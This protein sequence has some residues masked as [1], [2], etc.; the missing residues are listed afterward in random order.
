MARKRF[1][2]GRLFLRGKRT[3]K[4]VGR[5]REDVIASDGSTRRIEKSTVLGTKVEFPTRRLAERRLEQLLAR[6]NALGYRPARVAT[7]GAFAEQWKMKVLAQQ[8]PSSRLAG[9]S[10]LKLYILPEFG[11]MRLDQIGVENQQVFVTRLSKELSRKTVVNV[12]ATLSSMLNRARQWGYACEPVEFAR[13]ALPEASIGTVAR[14]FSADDARRIIEAASEPF[15]T[16]F[17]TLAMTGI[18]AGELLGLQVEDLDFE[19]RLI[20]I[21]RSA[22]YGRIQT[23]KSK[24]SQGALPMPEPLADM[25]KSYLNTWKPN[26]LRLLFANQIGRPMSANK[27]VQR[28]LW[29][30]LDKLKIPRC[31]LHAFRH[32]HS[33]LLVDSGAPVSVAQAQLR[34]ADPRITLGIY[35]H[36]VGNSQR[37]AV[38]KLA[39]ILRPN[40]P[41]LKPEDEWIQ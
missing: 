22:W 18:R 41:K 31:G 7:L 29:P 34:H 3:P 4:W 39:T 16:M 25:L 5:W 20:F 10:H 2:R 27:V 26:S 11:A 19:R 17:A 6:V 33:S 40:A 21:R 28:K 37:A 13:L 36:V 30:I 14:F 8:K 23:L 15:A 9:D 38:E 32:T 24:A 1:Q 12:L 35:S